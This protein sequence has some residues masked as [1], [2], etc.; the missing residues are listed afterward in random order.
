[1]RLPLI[2][3]A[4]TAGPNAVF[5]RRD[6]FKRA[7]VGL[8]LTAAP[9]LFAQA[10]RA[11][12]PAPGANA[13]GGLPGLPHH[14]AKAKRV[15]Y[16]HQ[17]G[18]PSQ[19]D[20]FDYKPGLAAL[21]G[22][23]LPG[24]VRGGQRLSTMTSGQKT[25]PIAPALFSFAQHGQCGRWLSE[26]IPHTAGIV[27]EVCLI[28][29]MFTE[30][31][32]HEPAMNFCSSGGQLPG[33]PSMGSWVTY[34][35]G[36]ENRDL[37]AFVVL[38]SNGTGDTGDQPIYDHLWSSGFLPSRLQ[39]VKFRNTGDPVPYLNDP[40][41]IDRATRR[42]VLDD[43]GALNRLHLEQCGQ[44][45][46]ATRIAQY[47]LAFRMQKSVP[48]LTDTSSESAAVLA[49]YGPEVKNPGS[50][51]ANCLLARRLVERGVRFVQLYH[52]GWDQHRNL[53][54]E[55]RN[56]CRDTDQPSAGLI[57]DLKNRG[58]L[59]DTLVV[60]G[61]EFGRTV[62]S[63]GTLTADNYGRDHHPRCF[64]LWMAGG[65]VKR[66]EVYGQT[67]DFSY[68]IVKDGVHIH[69]LHA[70]MLYLLGIDHR[71]LTYRF[72]GRDFRLTDVAGTVVP[73][74]MA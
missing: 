32:N 29:T 20:L 35:L 74:I 10:L 49:L 11:G 52:R 15:I 47:E 58:L 66:G 4:N 21:R 55:I 45:E 23:E 16:M 42:D 67:D 17:S 30:P 19:L 39:G 65:G 72:Q 61:G 18:A 31:V 43:V 33:R 12:E 46:I 44:S 24:S 48:E 50:Y 62:F 68:N 26:L 22:T 59:E 6:L 70:T 69:D 3:D 56:Q 5:G 53:P 27:D 57:A 41:G 28:Q 8:A 54:A 37:P 7:G 63:Q 34:A 14:P 51:A 13:N 25:F 36:S 1:M 38:T 71:R 40:A 60:W 9:V 73:G 64:S 2:Y